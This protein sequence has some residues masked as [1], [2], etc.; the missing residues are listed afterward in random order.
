MVHA[1]ISSRLDYCNSLYFAAPKYLLL[2]LQRVQNV[3][4]RLVLLKQRHDSISACFTTLH[5]LNIEQRSAYKILMIAFKCFH[6]SAPVLLS[7]LLSPC[8]HS[9][10]NS[11]YS[12]NL[13]FHNSKHGRR[14]F[15]Y[16][17]PRL[18]NCLPLLIRSAPNLPLFKSRLK[19]YI[20][21]S[22]DTLKQQYCRYAHLLP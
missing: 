17:A 18:W 12:F 1:V 5:W 10:R 8:L 3:A 11:N 22:Y 13:T 2:K 20:F 6:N 16:C 15:S 19:T 9:S 7:N 4:A 14:S 21:T